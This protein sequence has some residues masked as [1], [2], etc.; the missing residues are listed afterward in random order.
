M[1][2]IRLAAISAALAATA[3]LTGT[4]HAEP[5]GT[6]LTAGGK[7][8][9]RI[10]PCGDKLCGRIVWLAEPNNDQGQ[11]KRD[12]ENEDES[13]RSRPILGL[14]LLTGFPQQPE[15]GVWDDG[16]IYNPED[17]KTYSSEMEMADPDTL[18]VSG[19]VWVFCQSQIWKRVK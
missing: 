15:D 10:A 13:L 6:W 5:Q 2:R 16:E 1:H 12:A 18:K 7:S 17:G 19:C 9:V 11:P 4:A 14:P 8:H 3:A